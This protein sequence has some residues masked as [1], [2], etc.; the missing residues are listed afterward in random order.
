[1]KPQLYA[2]I[3]KESIDAKTV[4]FLLPFV[5]KE[6]QERIARLKF[7]KDRDLMLVGD[8]LAK[9]CIA[10]V[11]GVRFS[12]VQFA[13]GEH[14]KPYVNNLPHIHFNISHSGDWVVCAVCDKPVGVDVQKMKDA[15]FV[16]IAKRAFTKEE[17]KNFSK[18]PKED[19]RTQFYKTWTAKESYIKMLGT[20]LEDLRTAIPA[21]VYVD[22]FLARKDYMIS[23]CYG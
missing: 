10:K 6:K 5:E 17:Q 13:I 16:S 18:T 2:I 21:C 11:F 12:S 19:M 14:G 20:G 1:M 4:D 8:L 23:V 3:L 15:N 9:H 22:T 7:K